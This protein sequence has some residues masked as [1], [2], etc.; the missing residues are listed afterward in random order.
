MKKNYFL[1][2]IFLFASFFSVSAQ[3]DHTFVMVDSFGDG[4]NDATVDILVDDN[5]VV[6]AATAADSGLSATQSTENLLFA[7]VEGSSITLTNWVSGAWDSEI[8]WSILDGTG[9]V[10]AAGVFGQDTTVLANCTPPACPTPLITAWEMN[11]TG[12]SFDGTNQESV[13]S[14]TVEYSEATFTPGDGTAMS[15]TFESFPASLDGLNSSTT[16]YFAMVSNCGE[17]L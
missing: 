10:L 17:G 16:Y 2:L 9:L 7:A 6:P 12:V 5:V 8:S 13:S 4:W 11:P 15:Y 3:C 1:T 14:Y